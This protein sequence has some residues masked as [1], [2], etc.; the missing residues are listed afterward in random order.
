MSPSYQFC[1][2]IKIDLEI[3]VVAWAKY[4]PFEH[5]C[6]TMKAQDGSSN[7]FFAVVGPV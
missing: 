5:Y 7:L 3:D 6:S 1:L 2:A 4:L